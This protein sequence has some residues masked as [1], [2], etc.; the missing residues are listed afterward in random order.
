L[1]KLTP[2]LIEKMAELDSRFVELAE[3]HQRATSHRDAS[4]AE[5]DVM[6]EDAD[7][8]PEQLINDLIFHGLPS[9][10]FTAGIL[11]IFPLGRPMGMP[12]T[13][14]DLQSARIQTM[15]TSQ[16]VR[17]QSR[18]TLIWGSEVELPTNTNISPPKSRKGP[19]I[20]VHPPT[21]SNAQTRLASIPSRTD[22]RT[23]IRTVIDLIEEHFI[24]GSGMA[25]KSLPDTPNAEEHSARSKG[26]SPEYGRART[27]SKA[28]TTAGGAAA[29]YF[30]HDRHAHEQTRSDATTPIQQYTPRPPT[31]FSRVNGRHGP[32]HDSAPLTETSPVT[33]DAVTAQTHITHIVA[34]NKRA[35]DVIYMKEAAKP[36]SELGPWDHVTQRLYAWAIVW[37]DD[38]FTK[39][40]ENLALEKQVEVMPLTVFGMMT[41]K[42]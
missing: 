13:H 35:K 18:D 17:E 26:P 27:A 15:E 22:P 8:I 33:Q 3:E 7:T 2:Q 1:Q 28:P 4:Y 5:P 11:P 38:S 12:L 6:E 39:A 21:E 25:E 37:E 23:P 40:M 20:N 32:G 34:E 24:P 31:V 14:D 16:R 30:S 9:S 42:R 36:V 29:D 41:Y 19:T 10:A